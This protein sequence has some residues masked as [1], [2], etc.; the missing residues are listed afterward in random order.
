MATSMA[1]GCSLCRPLVE[2]GLGVR[3][4]QFRAFGYLNDA[5]G[6]QPAEYQARAVAED[7]AGAAAC[8]AALAVAK[9]I[10]ASLQE[11]IESLSSN[12]HGGAA[13]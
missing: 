3:L 7:A 8:A 11:E 10:A 6:L 4:E 12:L 9:A 13:G 1:T 2:G 5:G